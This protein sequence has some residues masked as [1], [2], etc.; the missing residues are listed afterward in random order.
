MIE[1]ENPNR[2]SQKNKKAAEVDVEAPRELTRRERYSQTPGNSDLNAFS[3]EFLPNS[4]LLIN[5]LIA[6]RRLRS[7]KLRSVT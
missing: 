5:V 2:V 1:I 3:V 4:G 6:G 7:R